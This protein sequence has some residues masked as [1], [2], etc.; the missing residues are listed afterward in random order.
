MALFD[1]GKVRPGAGEGV[2]LV[3][4]EARFHGHLS[5]KG[6]LRIEG[7]V[8]GNI[9]D[10]VTVDVGRKGKVR[11]DIAAESL[12]VAG[13]IEGNVVASRS[14]EI[15]AHGRLRGDLKTP[16]LRIEEGAF[17]EGHCAMTGAASTGKE[18]QGAG[19]PA[20]KKLP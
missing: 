11:G 16:S 18:G 2:T 20:G 8:E 14:V 6:S 7:F 15:L 3:A 9:T 1:G 10:G 19:L 5:A 12:S 4:E 17:F 13:D